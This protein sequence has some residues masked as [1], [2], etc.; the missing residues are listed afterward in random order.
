M[1]VRSVYRLS[2]DREN[3]GFCPVDGERH[4]RATE[5]T[6][7]VGV[8]TFLRIPPP[9]AIVFVV[10]LSVMMTTRAEAG[11]RW[12]WPLVGEVVREFERPVSDWA[13]GHRGID[14]RAIPG[15]EVRAP[16]AGRVTFVGPVAGR[17]VVVLRTLEDE[18]VTL[19]PVEASVLLGDVV[20]AGDVVGLLRGGHLGTNSLHL[21]IRV[22]GQYVDPSPYLP[23]QPRIVIYDSWLNSYALG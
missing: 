23:I 5:S 11:S 15:A 16:V 7:S 22:L 13:A 9:L 3:A 20:N 17:G 4:P 1:N 12:M 21:G 19:E 2:T 8:T 18:D 10:V 14:I 6:D